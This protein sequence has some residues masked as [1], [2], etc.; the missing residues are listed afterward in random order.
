MTRRPSVWVRFGKRLGLPNNGFVLS[1]I[2]NQSHLAQPNLGSFW[3]NPGTKPTAQ[4]WVRFVEN[5]VDPPR[6]ASATKPPSRLASSHPSTASIGSRHRRTNST[7][8]ETSRATIERRGCAAST[9]SRSFSQISSLFRRASNRICPWIF[10]ATLSSPMG[11]P[12]SVGNLYLQS[13][14]PLLSGPD[15]KRRLHLVHSHARWV[16]TRTPFQN[17]GMR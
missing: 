5:P 13:G 14:V 9:F 10:E 7:C 11:L 16:S 4:G 3:K 15:T 8:F 17:E 2:A 12:S 6:R 1:P